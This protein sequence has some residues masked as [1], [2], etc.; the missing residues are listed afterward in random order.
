MVT[1]N[2]YYFTITYLLQ[3]NSLFL[4]HFCLTLNQNMANK[5]YHNMFMKSYRGEFCDNIDEAYNHSMV[6]NKPF[7]D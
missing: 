2:I 1:P 7:Y 4:W 3:K 6:R 5:S